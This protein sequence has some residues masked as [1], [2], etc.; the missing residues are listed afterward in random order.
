MFTGPNI[1]RNGLV[2]YLEGNQLVSKYNQNYSLVNTQ[3]WTIGSGSVTGYSQNGVT[4]ENIRQLGKDPF[5]NN[6]VIWASTTDVGSDA[7]GVWNSDFFSVNSYA[8]YRF[9]VWIKKNVV[10]TI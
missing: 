7:D 5:G 6:T 10:V 1:S 8:T 3:T 2:L 9:S 4:A